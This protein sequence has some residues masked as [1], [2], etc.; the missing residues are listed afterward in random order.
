MIERID[1]VGTNMVHIRGS[2]GGTRTGKLIHWSVNGFVLLN[3]RTYTVYDGDNRK[4][5]SVAADEWSRR[6]SE[7]VPYY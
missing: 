2:H 4:V 6:R 3:G 5:A 7:F 1:P